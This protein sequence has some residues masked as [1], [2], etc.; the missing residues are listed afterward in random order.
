MPDVIGNAGGT[1]CD[2]EA[3]EAMDTVRDHTRLT[4]LGTS[5]LTAKPLADAENSR[6]G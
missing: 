3:I 6:A 2:Q 1:V 4:F 5:G